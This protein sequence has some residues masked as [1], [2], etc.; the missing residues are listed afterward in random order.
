ML[1]QS[2]ITLQN[3]QND[4]QQIANDYQLAINNLQVQ[5]AT[6]DLEVAITDN[7][8]ALQEAE[9]ELAAA[10][11]ELELALEA[12]EKFL[13]EQGLLRALQYLASYKVEIGK[14]LTASGKVITQETL[15]AQLN[16][17]TA[18]T[19]DPGAGTGVGGIDDVITFALFTEIIQEELDDQLVDLAAQQA[20]LVALKAVATDPA[21]AEAQR[22]ALQ[23]QVA[24]LVESNLA[25]AV[26]AAELANAKA[27]AT[28]AFEAAEDIIT[29]MD[30]GEFNNAATVLGTDYIANDGYEG[31]VLELAG[32]NTADKQTAVD[33]AEVALAAEEARLV[34]LAANVVTAQA[35]EDGKAAALETADQALFDAEQITDAAQIQ[36]DIA[37]QELANQS[38]ALNAALTAE[39]A[40]ELEVAD[41]EDD[42]ALEGS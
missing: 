33:D 10:E 4:A 42:V 25:L 23:L 24:Q 26:G 31:L 19:N 40:A 1:L 39:A 2:K 27:D 5:E 9:E 15:V 35:Y 28:D 21:T 41:A 8:T 22:D 11:L 12:L 13:E 14:Y 30:G 36:V 3:L 7:Q 17:L 37:A 38:A 16:T 6:S 29:T 32:L 20:A 34:T 18:Q